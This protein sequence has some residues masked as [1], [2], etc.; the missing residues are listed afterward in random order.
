TGLSE[1]LGQLSVN[2][3]PSCGTPDD[4]L[5]FVR[6][7]ATLV[8]QLTNVQMDNSPVTGITVCERI[9][10]NISCDAPGLLM[11]GAIT[12]TSSTISIGIKGGVDLAAGD[13]ITVSGIRGRIA[14]SV[15]IT[16]NTEAL[17]QVSIVPA[18]AATFLNDIGVLARSAEPLS[19]LFDTVPEVPCE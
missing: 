17:G 10:G 2:A 5:C 4:L 9:N 15:L 3:A 12:A 18:S 16:K 19:L 6:D 13:S 7:P 8:L 11:T 1:V 14:E